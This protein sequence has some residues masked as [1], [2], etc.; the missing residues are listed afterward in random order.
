M[1]AVGGGVLLLWSAIWVKLA[2]E[3][4]VFCILLMPAGALAYGFIDWRVLLYPVVD[5]VS[6]DGPDLVVRKSG[7][8]ERV[9]LTAIKAVYPSLFTNPER[10]T[11]RL[12]E[13]GPFGDTIDFVLPWRY[14]RLPFSPHPLAT[15][16]REIV[17]LAK[18]ARPTVEE[19]P[20]PLAGRT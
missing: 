18:V 1:P 8:E 12:L 13:P 16:L 17:R 2:V 7:R 14:F 20:D 19:R 3:D 11:L 10:I 9:P 5:S 15:E 4:H 6:L